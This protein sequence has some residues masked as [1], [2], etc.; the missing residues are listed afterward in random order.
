MTKIRTSRK[1]ELR[2]NELIEA[3][4]RLWQWVRRNSGYVLL[5]VSVVALGLFL[6][7]MTTS[8]RAES[9]GNLAGANLEISRL[10]QADWQAR[11]SEP[12]LKPFQDHVEQAR[13]TALEARAQLV[14]GNALLHVLN[15]SDRMVRAADSEREEMIARAESAFNGALQAAGENAAWRALAHLGLAGVARN[16]N[17]F[18][19]AQ[20]HATTAEQ[21]P[22]APAFVRKLAEAALTWAKD[23]RE[24]VYFP[25]A[26]PEEPEQPE[27]RPAATR[28]APPAPEQ[29][30][31]RPAATQPAPALTQPASAEAGGPG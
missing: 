22:G 24:P 23:G 17:D 30:D 20:R 19:A 2:S 6:W 4:G 9:E 10:L 14:Y 27:S 8:R 12:G 13:G 1:E 5:G 26:P 25:P 16:R 15:T 21:T 18:E 3:L 11:R 29:P 31:S 7:Y 28:P